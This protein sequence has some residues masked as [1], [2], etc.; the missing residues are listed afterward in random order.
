MYVMHFLPQS[1][2]H[3]KLKM[4]NKISIFT[5]LNKPKTV[6]QRIKLCVS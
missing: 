1:F 2:W 4:V 6:G 3:E 5:G